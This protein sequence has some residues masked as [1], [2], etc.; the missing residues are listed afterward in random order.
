MSDASNDCD[1][2]LKER[3]IAFIMRRNLEDALFRF[4]MRRS[5]LNRKKVIEWAEGAE[6]LNVGP[7]I[8]RFLAVAA[9]AKRRRGIRKSS[10]VFRAAVKCFFI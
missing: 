8:E 7:R 10:K 3:K 6:L 1:R 9:V 5:L 4:F 2:E